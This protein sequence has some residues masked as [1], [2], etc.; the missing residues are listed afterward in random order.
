MRKGNR[1]WARVLARTRIVCLLVGV[2][3]WGLLVSGWCRAEEPVT[4]GKLLF[5]RHCAACHGEKGDGNGVA[6]RFLNPKPR[7][8]T[9]PSFRLVTTT[10]LKPSD[11]DLMNVIT[12]GM[13]GSAMF[14]FA[15]LD[16]KER[17]ALVG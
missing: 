1:L 14:P 6:A 2:T 5:E 7:D 8:F 12:R 9:K 13:P 4:N 15:H 17:Q 11:D 3:A 16:Q 10:N